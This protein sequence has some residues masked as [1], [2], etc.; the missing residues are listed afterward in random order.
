LKGGLKKD[1]KERPVRRDERTAEG[2]EQ[3]VAEQQSLRVVK[4]VV[5]LNLT[6][7]SA[8]AE[9]SLPEQSI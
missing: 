8:S 4:P 3:P 2:A 5:N 6:E 9:K 7:R 1:K